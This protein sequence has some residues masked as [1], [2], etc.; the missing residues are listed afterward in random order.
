MGVVYS[1]EEEFHLKVTAKDVGKYVILCGDPGRC[2]AI[3][4]YFDNAEFVRSNREYTLYTGYVDGVKASVCSTGIGGPSAA[5]AMEELI[6]C[7]ADT[8]IRVGTSGGMAVEVMGGDLVIGTGAIRMEGTSKEYAPIEFP[9]VAN[10][11]VVNALVEA[12]E[13]FPVRSHVGVLQCKD[14]FYGQHDPGSMPVGYELKE[15]WD[16]WVKCGA[17]A[18]EMESAALFTVGSVRKVRAGSIMLV[19][20]NQTR[21]ELGLDDPMSQ[22]IDPAIQVTVEA[23]R[24]LIE[25][26]KKK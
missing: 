10:Y 3:A 15:K 23:V 19:F 4:Q 20:A 1:K 11:Q 5:I 24:I 12:A 9:A 18:S 8:F 16:A 6:H 25:K 21:R 26:D 17:L 13:K 14:S 7:G 2:K 22:D